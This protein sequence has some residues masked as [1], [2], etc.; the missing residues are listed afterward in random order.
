[1]IGLTTEQF[2]SLE[3]LSMKGERIANMVS[4]IHSGMFESPNSPDNFEEA[5][6]LFECVIIDYAKE[7]TALF[8]NVNRERK[9]ING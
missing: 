5:H 7:L 3:E 8:D 1:M 2:R 6:H 9:C 4:L